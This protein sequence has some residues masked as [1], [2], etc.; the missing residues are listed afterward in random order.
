MGDYIGLYR[1]YNIGFR[2]KGLGPKIL[3]GDYLGNY[4][5]Y[6]GRY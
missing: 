2:V 1:D 4:K 6:Y 3:K 5:G